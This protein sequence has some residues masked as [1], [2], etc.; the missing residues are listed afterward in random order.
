MTLPDQ[1][2]PFQ[3]FWQL[4]SRCLSGYLIHDITVEGNS[5]IRNVTLLAFLFTVA[6]SP[7]F[8]YP[9]FVVE[10]VARVGLTDGID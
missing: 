5:A 4:D 3:L 9:P 2:A 1:P 8:F 7:P 6:A 10:P